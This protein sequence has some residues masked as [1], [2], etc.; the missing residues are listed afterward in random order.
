MNF[1]TQLFFL[2]VEIKCPLQISNG[3]LSSSC[4]GII[5]EKC[6]FVCKYD[7]TMKPVNLKCLPEGLWDKDTKAICSFKDE[8]GKKLKVS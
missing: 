5:G 3:D 1:T 6:E 7:P 4:L 8:C 2:F